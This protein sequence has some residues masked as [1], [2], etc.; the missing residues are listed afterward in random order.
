MLLSTRIDEIKLQVGGISG[1]VARGSKVPPVNIIVAQILDIGESN[2]EGFQGFDVIWEGRSF[3]SE[4]RRGTID[5][6][7]E[8]NSAATLIYEESEKFGQKKMGR[9][10]IKDFLQ[11]EEGNQCFGGHRL[12]HDFVL[13]L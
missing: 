12:C 11:L 9:T 4:K 3:C 6:T 8:S 1:R 7:E 13:S 2:V 5:H 10:L